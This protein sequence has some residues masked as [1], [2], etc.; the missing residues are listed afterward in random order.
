MKR[1][2]RC[3]KLESGQSIVIVALAMVA[4]LAL[5][6]L[7]IDG[8]NLFLQRRRAQNAAD[9]GSL[10]G[11]RVLAELL[12]KCESGA[13][14]DNVV[15]EKVTDMIESNGFLKTDGSD[16]TAYY[17]D[18]NNIQVGV[19]GAS[20]GNIPGSATGVMVDL[21]AVFPTHFMK[22]VGINNGSVGVDATAMTGRVLYPEGNLI[23]IGVPLK[24]AGR[25]PS[26][27]KWGVFDDSEHF[28][29]LQPDGSCD[30]IEAGDPHSQRGWLN[31]NYIYNRE[32]DTNADILNRTCSA[33]VGTNYC[34]N[35]PPGLRGYASGLCPYKYAI[36]AG[37]PP[38]PDGSG[39][40]INYDYGGD[41][42]H[43]EPGSAAS[44]SKSIYN[45]YE[46]GTVLYAP[47]F[48]RVYDPYDEDVWDDEDDA[49]DGLLY[50]PPPD[51][52]EELA[53][54]CNLGGTDWPESGSFLYHVVGFVA[55]GLEHPKE[56][57]EK[58]NNPKGVFGQFKDPWIGPGMIDP[59]DGTEGACHENLIFGV[60][61][62]E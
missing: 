44:A 47:V 9:A 30:E 21:G 48:D 52:S 55:F 40:Y 3:G 12:A 29:L 6:G 57:G 20:G 43:G 35:P 14:M 7:A 34:N 27:N 16:W 2:R 18:K 60:N 39:G 32:Q 19:V 17:V 45:N 41:Y 8:G 56:F 5:A 50:M 58:I 54:D 25:A 61:L 28:C 36:W 23:P 13:S 42:I 46:I 10:G 62:W 49:D 22:V 15:E 59:S 53:Y 31:L 38:D 33:V 24:V 4:M 26:P 11:T 51:A 37:N 1:F